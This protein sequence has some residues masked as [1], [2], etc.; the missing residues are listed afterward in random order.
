[1]ADLAIVKAWKDDRSGNLMHGRTARNI[2]PMIAAAG[3]AAVAE[4]RELLEVRDIDPDEVQSPSIFVDRIIQ[5]AKYEER[6]E[7]LTTRPR[8]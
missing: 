6:I 2:N 3:R 5:G 4:V 7:R 1:M 8:D